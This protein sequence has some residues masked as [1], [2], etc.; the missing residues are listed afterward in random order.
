MTWAK[1]ICEH[2]FRQKF[3]DT[4]NPLCRCGK[5]VE[6]SIHLLFSCPNY[7]DERSTLLNKIRNINPNISIN[8]NS[9][10]TQ[11]FLYRDKD[12]TASTFIILNSTV[13]YILTTKGLDE[14]FF[15]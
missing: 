6:T 2:E 7:S 1:S 15:L 5:E 10:I 13:E 14:P 3:Q 9:Q 11:F 8:T 4:L 12:F